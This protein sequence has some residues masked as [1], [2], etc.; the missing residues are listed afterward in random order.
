[1]TSSDLEGKSLTIVPGSPEAAARR[2]RA[3]NIIRTQ[4]SAGTWA[5]VNVG[6]DGR[7]FTRVQ[8]TT[9]LHPDAREM[10]D[11]LAATAGLRICEVLENL[12]HA[13]YLAAQETSHELD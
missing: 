2:N 4:T 6:P 3:G 10:L 9:K 13:A 11:Q 8:L 12:I 5:P 7:R 1:L